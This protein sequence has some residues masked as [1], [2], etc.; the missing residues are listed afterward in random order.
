MKKLAA[1]FFVFAMSMTTIFAST[2]DDKRKEVS[3]EEQKILRQEI[4]KLLGN[5]NVQETLKVNVSFM[6]NAKGEIIVLSVKNSNRDIDRYIKSSL[7]YQKISNKIMKRM[8]VYRL[9]IVI[10]KV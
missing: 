10:R 5:Y 1:L 7:N 2:G 9:P 4:V 8:K 6:I 3:K